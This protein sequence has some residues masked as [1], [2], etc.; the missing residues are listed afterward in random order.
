MAASNIRKSLEEKEKVKTIL[1]F[2]H[3][4]EGRK[5]LEIGC[6]KGVTSFFLRQTGGVWISADIDWN[7]ALTTRKLVHDRVLYFGENALPFKKQAFDLIIAIDTL[8]HIDDDETFLKDV[9]RILKPDGTL[10]VS[11]PCSDKVLF[12][13]TLAQKAGMTLEYYGHKRTGYTR[14]GLREKLS[15]TGFRIEKFEYFSRFFTEFIELLINFSYIF[16]LNRGKKQ[17][18]IKGSIA[19]SNQNDFNEHSDA[20]RLYGKI[21]PVLKIIAGMDRLIPFTRGY[22]CILA[23]TKFQEPAK[24]FPETDAV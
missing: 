16:I 9:G 12:L 13:N 17:E 14:K 5:C 15:K 2:L 7:N 8:E 6:E 20:F 4:A 1:N 11:V 24:Q 19:P 21:H 3:P 18:G 23:A 10:Y 22:A